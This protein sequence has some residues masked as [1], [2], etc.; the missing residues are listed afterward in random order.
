[1][2]EASISNQRG[3]FLE[4]LDVRFAPFLSSLPPCEPEVSSEPPVNSVGG[5]MQIVTM[6]GTIWARNIENIRTVSG[7][8]A[9]GVAVY[10]V[11]RALNL[12]LLVSLC[13]FAIQLPAQTEPSKTPASAAASVNLWD[14][15]LNVSGYLV[16]QGQSYASPT[17]T[18]DHDT[19]HLEARYNYE[20]Q[21]T[22]SLW[23]GYN[24]SIGKQL[25]LDATP[26]I[27][28]VFGNVNAIAP[29]LEFTVTYKKLALYSADEYLFDTSTKSGNFFYT[30]TQLT[31]S[32][33]EWFTFGYVVQRTRAYQ[34][35]LDIQRGFL[36]GFTHKKVQFTTQIFNVGQADPTVVLSLGC[37]FSH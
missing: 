23:A 18:V 8:R 26:M 34:T 32:P 16:P 9:G 33:L 10:I 7:V 31:Y 28:G 30:W 17:F 27:G 25:V 11:I 35:P 22:G 2:V 1:M 15:N 19:V 5:N 3:Q 6:Y 13:L 4:E 14:F 20:A 36:V 29:G 21:R 37:S 24:L 12:G